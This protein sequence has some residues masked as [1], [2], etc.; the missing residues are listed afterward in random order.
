MTESQVLPAVARGGVWEK[1]LYHDVQESTTRFIIVKELIYGQI[2]MGIF[3]TF[4]RKS[5]CIEV[6]VHPVDSTR[7][8][9]RI[10]LLLG[11]LHVLSGG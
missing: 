3:G 2:R 7:I 10:G 8:L 1:G 5:R 6:Y 4:T 9:A 11:I